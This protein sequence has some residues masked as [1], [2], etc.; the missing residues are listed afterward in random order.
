MPGRRVQRLVNLCAEEASAWAA[1]R[2]REDHAGGTLNIQADMTGIPMR[3]EDLA[4]VSGKN[5]EPK[6][7]QVK[8][9]IVFRQET[10]GQGEVQRVPW[11]TT[12]VVTFDDVTSFSPFCLTPRGKEEHGKALTGYYHRLYYFPGV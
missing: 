1:K 11:S 12:R 6:K 5:G 7:R 8:G 4:G 2:K 10:N 9:G 3:K